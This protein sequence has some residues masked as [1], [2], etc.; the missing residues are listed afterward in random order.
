[1]GRDGA[2]G[3]LQLR[4]AGAQTFAQDEATSIVYGMPRAAWENGGAQARLPLDR[5]ASYITARCG[6][7]AIPRPVTP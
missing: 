5:A 4:N 6:Q 2:D 1:M 7:P 3:L